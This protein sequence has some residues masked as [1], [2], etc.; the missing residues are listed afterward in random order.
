MLSRLLPQFEGKKSDCKR[1]N[2]LTDDCLHFARIT[3]V[4]PMKLLVAQFL[5]YI[6]TADEHTRNFEKLGETV[7][8]VCLCCF[9]PSK[10]ATFEWYCM[11]GDGKR[12]TV[13]WSGEFPYFFPTDRLNRT[14]FID[15]ISNAPAFILGIILLHFFLWNLTFYMLMSC[16]FCVKMTSC[17]LWTWQCESWKK[18]AVNAAFRPRWHRSECKQTACALGLLTLLPKTAL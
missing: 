12:L 4:W 5:R 7:I 17:E 6:T 8:Y 2:L 9:T 14:H 3:F 1:Q 18:H 11:K 10:M 16:R 13:F 15:M